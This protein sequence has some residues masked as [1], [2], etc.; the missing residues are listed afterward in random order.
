MTLSPAET[1][2]SDA[3]YFVDLVND[4]LQGK[5]QD[6]DFATNS[7]RVYSTLDLTCSTL[8]SSLSRK[9]WR[10]STSNFERRRGKKKEGQFPQVALVALDPYTG[11]I[12]ALVGGRNYTNSQLNR[13]L[14]KRQPG[15][16]FKP[17]VYRGRLNE[18]AKNSGREDIITAA[19]MFLDEPTTFTFNQSDLRARELSR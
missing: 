4:D 7:Y 5:F 9:E 16:A 2:S 15:S 3:P 17:F 19:S 11:D 8:R 13:A 6:W 14:A 12:K 1:E 18:G 10:N